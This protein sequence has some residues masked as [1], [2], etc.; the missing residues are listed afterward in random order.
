MRQFVPPPDNNRNNESRV[1]FVDCG[2][3]RL[4]LTGDLE[5]NG[6]LELL[7]QPGFIEV[8]QG[9]DILV[10]PHHGRESGVCEEAFDWLSPAICLISDGPVQATSSDRYAM[11]ANG[12]T[13]T[14]AVTGDVSTRY[15]LTT[16]RDGNVHCRLYETGEL[17]IIKGIAPR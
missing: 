13:V 2:S 7:D 14:D 9:T 4:A 8:L 15:T 6:W 12:W 1:L 5:R 10:A 16:R 17:Q 11:L 3:V